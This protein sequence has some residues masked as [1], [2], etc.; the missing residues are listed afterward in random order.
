MMNIVQWECTFVKAF[1]DPN[2]SNMEEKSDYDILSAK[3]SYSILLSTFA[4]ILVNY[5]KT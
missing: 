3:M 5:M 1:R 4:C 2:W